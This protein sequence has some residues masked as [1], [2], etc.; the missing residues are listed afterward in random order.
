M[1]EVKTFNSEKSLQDYIRTVIDQLPAE[2]IPGSA[3]T[4]GI[5]A[6][7][8]KFTY[9]N[10]TTLTPGVENPNWYIV[11]TRSEVALAN[12][13]GI[14]GSTLP[15]E[16]MDKGGF[17]TVL[18]DQPPIEVF[19]NGGV[20][21][22]IAGTLSYR[23]SDGTVILCQDENQLLYVLNTF[24]LPANWTIITKGG[25]YVLA[26]LEG[27]PAYSPEAQ[28][29]F[30]RMPTTPTEAQ[31]AP[32]ANFVDSQQAIGNW[33]KIDDFFFFTNALGWNESNSLT[34]WKLKTASKI[35]IPTLGAGG[36]KFNGTDQAIDTNYNPSVDAINYSQN[37][38]L[39]GCYNYGEDS[40]TSGVTE[41]FTNFDSGGSRSRISYNVGTSSQ[42]QL[43]SA[44][45]VDTSEITAPA[46]S[47]LMVT[48]DASN[49]YAFKNGVQNGVRAI[50]GDLTV[51]NKTWHIGSRDGVA[52]FYDGRITSAVLGSA[53]GFNHAS[54]NTDLVS[55]LTAFGVL[56]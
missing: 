16:L 17:F 11:T 49:C 21:L 39:A 37:D 46:L 40:I 7:G 51:G 56:P 47:L 55:L 19:L 13:L 27:S 2:G 24:T 54:F 48:R 35:G 12:Y 8:G 31:K 44:N 43:N 32:I 34:G 38:A 26:G 25:Q 4:W 6:K 53:A 23:S 18:G 52:A 41:L 36:F 50:G 5:V 15:M 29:V 14:L 9:W 28:A 33:A 10:K 20:Y 45:A 42:I 1:A 3:K 22:E 30:D